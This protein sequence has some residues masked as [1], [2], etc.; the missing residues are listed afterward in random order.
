MLVNIGQTPIIQHHGDREVS[1]K[2]S[3]TVALADTPFRGAINFNLDEER[4]PILGPG[5]I[6][7]FDG[8]YDRFTGEF[9]MRNLQVIED[10]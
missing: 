6:I 9:Q 7:E 3:G 10:Y 8:G 2:I 4:P 1:L 5:E